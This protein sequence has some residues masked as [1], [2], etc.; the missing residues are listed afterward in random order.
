[1]QKYSSL[2]IGPYYSFHLKD[3]IRPVRQAPYVP[4]LVHNWS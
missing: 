3:L 4:S 1:M 2:D